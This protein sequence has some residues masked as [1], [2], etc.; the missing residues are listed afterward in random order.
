[1]VSILLALLE[2]GST[3]SAMAGLRVPLFLL[4]L[5][6]CAAQGSSECLVYRTTIWGWGSNVFGVRAPPGILQ[7]CR[8]SVRREGAS[9][10]GNGDWVIFYG[11]LPLLDSPL[12]FAAT[13]DGPLA[14]WPTGA[15]DPCSEPRHRRRAG[16]NNVGL[17]VQRKGGVL[18]A[19]AYV[20]A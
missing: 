2:Q 20:A 11:L 12:M 16:R 17:Q 10:T 8:L 4:L 14:V 5:S 7:G 3:G 18:H 9:L 19:A 13:I 15:A 1:M 6:C